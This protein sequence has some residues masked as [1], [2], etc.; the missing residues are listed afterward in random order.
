MSARNISLVPLGDRV[1][2]R[3]VDLTAEENII[4]PEQAR[5]KPAVGKVLARGLDCKL[6]F[7]VL[8]HVFYGQFTGTPVSVTGED[9]LLIREDDLIAVVEGL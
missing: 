6:P 2:V 5:E 7:R 1:L 3:P 4:I 8:E 9:L